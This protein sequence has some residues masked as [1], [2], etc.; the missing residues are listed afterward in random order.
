MRFV[1]EPLGRREYRRWRRSLPQR[2]SMAGRL[3]TTGLPGRLVDAGFRL[4]LLMR[5]KVPAGVTA[6]AHTAYRDH[7][8]PD[9]F[10]YY[11]RVVRQ[12]GYICLQ[13]W[14]FYAMNDWRS[15]FHGV[16][17]HEADW[18]LA[19]VYLV[20]RDGERPQPVWAAFSSHDYYGDDL[21]RRW[22]DPEL[23][24]EGDHPIV[25]AGAGSHSGAFVPGDYVVR[26]D[27]PQLRALLRFLRR[28]RR[29]PLRRRPIERESGFGIPFVDYMRGDGVAIGP[30]HDAT[31][32]PVLIHDETPWVRDYKGLWGLDTRDRFGGERAPAG[33]RYER[34]GSVRS[35]WA[36]PLGWAGLLKVPPR[37][38]DVAVLLAERVT[39][40][41]AEISALDAAVDA[42]EVAVRRLRAE[43]RS[44]DAHAPSR[45]LAATRWA[46]VAEREGALNETISTRTR[47]AEERQAHLGTLSRPFVP[48][49][50]QAHIAKHHQPLGEEPDART[51][52]L[53]LW[54]KVSV[55]LLLG[56]IA[57][58]L[59]VS[60]LALITTIVVLISAFIGMEALA[61]G[62]F[63]SFLVGLV[64]LVGAVAL[65][66]AVVVLFL[67]HWRVAVSVLIGLGALI[68]LM[69]NL[70]RG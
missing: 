52:L 58:A 8:E 6:A 16:N 5:G 4:S 34:G 25:C 62:R 33:P 15:T 18:E 54:A 24:R 49:P 29:V 44:L 3:T 36:N 31:W 2:F 17:D 43:A 67:D 66:A 37:D 45:G 65:S 53:R 69:G 19:T 35:A 1:E 57:L 42:Q 50:P 30:G 41:D 9:S 70:L 14:F 55:P 48:E 64:V 61:R 27:P 21:R 32:N 60:P 13:Y 40:L 51:R 68:L 11:G 63:V 59:T 39:G 46:E 56:C 10:P 47:L 12:G 38:D 22:D 23:R 26:V 20:E 7:L 28:V